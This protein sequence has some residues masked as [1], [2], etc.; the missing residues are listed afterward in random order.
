VKLH[1]RAWSDETELNA[2]QLQPGDRILGDGTDPEETLPG[3]PVLSVTH[4]TA[5]LAGVAVE[6]TTALVWRGFLGGL[7]LAWDDADARVWVDRG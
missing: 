7:N 4:S 1:V 5:R 6:R 2:G 3:D